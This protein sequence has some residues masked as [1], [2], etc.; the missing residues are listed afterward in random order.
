MEKGIIGSRSIDM[1]R[2]TT[3]NEK[4]K[5]DKDKYYCKWV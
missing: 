4:T 5:I 3:S 2:D 1:K